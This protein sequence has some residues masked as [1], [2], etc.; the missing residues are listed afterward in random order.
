MKFSNQ[1]HL[2][3]LVLSTVAAAPTASIKTLAASSANLC[4]TAD[5]QTVSYN[6][7]ASYS[8]TC[9][10]DS[11]HG[12]YGFAAA[13]SSYLDCMTL[14]DADAA[15]N[16]E[17]FVYVGGQGGSGAGTCWL[18][19]G[20]GTYTPAGGNYVSGFKGFS[21]I[22]CP[23]SNGTVYTTTNGDGFLIEC[24]IDHF[25]G[26]LSSVP[27]NSF[28]GCLESCANTSGCLDV[29]FSG[30]V[31]YMKSTLTAPVY[32]ENIWGAR[33]VSGTILPAGV[34]SVG[35]MV[36][37]VSARVLTY[38][39]YS[40]STNTPYQCS[41]A[42]RALGYKYAG[43]EYSAECFCGNT[44]PPSTAASADCNMP[45]TGNSNLTCGGPNRLSVTV[46]NNAQQQVTAKTTIGTWT[47]MSCYSDTAS[48]RTLPT[49]VGVAGGQAN[50]TNANCLSSCAAQ[51]LAYCG[52]EYSG[53]CWASNTKPD[54]G[55]GLSGDAVSQGCNYPCS[56]SSADVCGGSNRVLAYVNG[57][58]KSSS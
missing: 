2:L 50:M 19:S 23:A 16:C 33:Q 35:C 40:N 27:A 8:I 29:A 48:N 7:S 55:R 4:P 53:E 21:A 42:C 22:S 43:T 58:A 20:M 24:G 44:K 14:C 1:P 39:A 6:S 56:G 57:A 47:L 3:L 5:G 11:T 52:T 13:A 15:N 32:N 51:G 26:D 45:C 25:S 9:S 34:S 30:A 46:D 17:G 31:C 41:L 18:K 54:A 36:D 28:A 38:Q 10:S 37:I 12:A 49:A